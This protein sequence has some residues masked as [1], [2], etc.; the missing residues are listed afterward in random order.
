MIA[1][2]VT[3]FLL[4]KMKLESDLADDWWRIKYEDIIFPEVVAKS[5]RKSVL[6]LAVS[7]TE[8]FVSGKTSSARVPSVVNSLMSAA[9]VIDSVL[10]GIYKGIKVA[11]KPL[12]IKKI[13]LSRSLLFELKQVCKTHLSFI[14]K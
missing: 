12:N 14:S 1:L 5:G 9:G 7:E 10:V 8:G 3:F 11:V 13:N 6:S 2:I 4:K